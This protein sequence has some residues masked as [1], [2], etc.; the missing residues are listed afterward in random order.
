MRHSYK[1]LREGNNCFV[2]SP[3]RCIHLSSMVHRHWDN[4]FNIEGE[5]IVIIYILIENRQAA[6]VLLTT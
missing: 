1:K 2:V 5:F 6:K 4:L 3:I